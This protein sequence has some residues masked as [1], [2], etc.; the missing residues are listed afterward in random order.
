MEAYALQVATEILWERSGRQFGLCTFKLR[1]CKEDCLP[2]GPLIPQTNMTG[3]QWPFP[4][5]I[6]GGWVNIACSCRGD[7]SCTRIHQVRLPYPIADIVEVKV[8]GAVLPADSY[9]VDDYRHLVRLDG[10]PWPR[11]NDLTLADT[12]VGT[13]SVDASYGTVVPSS[14]SLA[15]GELATEIMRACLD[16]DCRLNPQVTQVTRQGTQSQVLNQAFG[17]NL[18]LRFSDMFI[19]TV[20]PG[21]S[22]LAAV[23]DIDGASPRRVGT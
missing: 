7:C 17:K 18:G 21:R 23:Y 5:K 9:R 19:S 2:P 15:V 16:L 6:S 11:C 1:P 8:D 10:E 20:N 12:E 4:A 3:W 22:R 14:G 13:W